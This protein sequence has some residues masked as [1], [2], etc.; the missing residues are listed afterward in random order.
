M[1][2]ARAAA[3]APAAQRRRAPRAPFVL[4]V[5]G[6]LCGGLV[7]L[8]LLNTVLAQ[9]SL[10][11]DELRKT[12]DQLRQDVEE[13]KNDNM[14]M[15]MP[16]ALSRNSANQGLEPDWDKARVITLDRSAGSRAASEG[17]TPVG[18]ERVPGTGR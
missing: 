4:L 9:D 3:P 17:Q 8:L 1:P 2:V 6:L 15:E 18:Q 13:L 12:N 10:R 16:D 7:S 5:V 14:R 11:A